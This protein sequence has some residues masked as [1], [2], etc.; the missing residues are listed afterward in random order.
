MISKYSIGRV[1]NME[2]L[3]HF[4]D[5]HVHWNAIIAPKLRE[6]KVYATSG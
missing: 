5:A 2:T 6:A 4:L 3:M 1:D